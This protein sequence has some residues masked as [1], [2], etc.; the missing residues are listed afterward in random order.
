M[1]NEAFRDHK[2]YFIFFVFFIVSIRVFLLNAD[3]VC[4]MTLSA[5]THF[6]PYLTENETEKKIL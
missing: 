4:R 2:I 1:P 5:A 6:K 3:S